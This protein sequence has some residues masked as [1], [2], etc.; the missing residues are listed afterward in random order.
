MYSN[1]IKSRFLLFGLSIL[2]LSSCSN[3]EAIEARDYNDQIINH[4]IE[5]I[6][7]IDSLENS[8]SNYNI[9]KMEFF[10]YRLRNK[11]RD[12][13]E[14]A[15]S[16]TAINKDE[17][18]KI[19]TQNLFAVYQNLSENEYPKI[20]QILSMPDSTYTDSDQQRLF[21][22]QT[23]IKGITDEAHESFLE[24]QAEFGKKHNLNFSK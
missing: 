23:K 15:N 18:L 22:Q 21:D 19:G 20:I 12:G 2:I 8:F 16:L 24:I 10:Q 3:S 14:L 1:I 4:Q 13:V 6:D 5:I 11:I 7:A 9:E 17:S